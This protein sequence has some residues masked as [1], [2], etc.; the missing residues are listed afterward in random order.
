[1]YNNTTISFIILGIMLAT[2]NWLPEFS[3]IF[4]W[5]C[6][7]LTSLVRFMERYC[8]F[9]NLRSDRRLEIS[10]LFPLQSVFLCLSRCDTRPISMYQSD[11]VMQILERKLTHT[12]KDR[13]VFWRTRLRE[14]MEAAILNF[15]NF[16]KELTKG[17]N[18][19]EERWILGPV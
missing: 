11:G 18:L 8:K 13:Y 19:I 16:C 12:R 15:T 1:M 6:R 14:T 7:R 4:C 5:W 9:T 17:L 3:Y 10:N 2:L